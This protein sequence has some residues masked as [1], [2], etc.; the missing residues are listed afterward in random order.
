MG[1]AGAKRD[2]TTV[3]APAAPAP[4]ASSDV[5]LTIV[6]E[7]SSSST[8]MKRS[9][10]AHLEEGLKDKQRQVCKFGLNCYR[11]NPEHLA[12]F[13]HPGDDDYPLAVRKAG[14]KGH[15]LTLHQCFQFCDPLAK[16][17]IDDKK[18]LGELLWHLDKAVNT[19]ELQAVWEII[20][21]DGNG[22]CSFTEFAEW[23]Q[24]YGIDKP[25]GLE[26]DSPSG[27]GQQLSCGFPGCPCKNFHE[28]VHE[29]GGS[30][31]IKFC[32]CGH[33]R[34]LHA[35]TNSGEVVR[36]PSY[37]ANTETQ[38]E[39]NGFM[40]WVR[41][42]AEMIQQL[43][44]ML[45]ASVKRTWTRDRGKGVKVPAGYKIRKANR[46][47]NSKVWR[48]YAM[49][50]SML[51]GQI[52][53]NPSGFKEYGARTT[54]DWSGLSQMNEAPLEKGINE[55]YLWH[56]TS[57]EGAEAI[58]KIDF[59]QRLAGSATGTLYGPGTYF[60]ESCTKADEYAKMASD[61]QY[62]GLFCMLLCRVMG[63]RVLYTDE[64]EPNA[65][66]LVDKVLHGDYDSVLGDRE[67]CRNTFKEFVI[68]SG[69][70][71]YAEYVIF[72]ERVWE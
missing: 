17:I 3:I 43:Q 12:Q 10:T 36:V 66:D 58:C 45:D 7:T 4:S 25:L 5:S 9:S 23:A 18:L 40:E 27:K 21:D 64:A 13:C 8:G 46:N 60:A 50:R 47:E 1:C 33:K 51:R 70:Q 26:V 28:K 24:G 38:F 57:P 41:C 37:W 44:R 61:G 34:S 53:N 68:F 62:E 52:N 65:D 56:G 72:Y 48:K 63:G 49:Q 32:V 42:D 69:D 55:W 30:G 39:M 6:R 29:S 16:G 22:Y 14:V 59:K 54:V 15:F 31:I 20:D 11:K 67:K 2:D 35:A 71:A 19:D